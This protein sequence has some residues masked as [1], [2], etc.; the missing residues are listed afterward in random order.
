MDKGFYSVK[1]IV[2]LAI[3]VLLVLLLQLNKVHAQR[4]TSHNDEIM[5]IHGKWA[6][7][8]ASNVGSDPGF[9]SSQYTFSYRRLDSIT[10]MLKFVYPDPRGMEVVYYYNVGNRPLFP[11]A[12][13]A[14]SHN[15]L[16]KEYF[17]VK[18]TG[19]ILLN[20]ETPTW[21]HVYVNYFNWFV[22]YRYGNW[23]IDGKATEVFSLM[24][25]DGTWNGLPLYKKTTQREERAVLISRDGQL[26]YILLTQKQYLLALRSNWENKIRENRKYHEDQEK[27]RREQIEKMK[28]NKTMDPA[29]KE[30]ALANLQKDYDYYIKNQP[31]YISKSDQYFEKKIVLI[32]NYI[33]S[34]S[35]SELQQ[36]VEATVPG[37]FDGSFE[38][39]SKKVVPTQFARINPAYFKKEL[40]RYIPQFI[41][42]YWTWGN[43]TSSLEIKKSLEEKFPVHRLKAL[44]DK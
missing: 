5:S 4:D 23:M 36:A 13:A 24:Q 15:S 19:K 7:E 33:S 12:P 2:L 42:L 28:V 29:I 41:V 11:N 27:N 16:Y 1:D 26:P 40:P 34:H 18:S 32:N 35:E 9:P 44:L 17:Y 43:Y 38:P 20:D 30:K 22:S 14:Y 8:G 6:K 31:T 10:A 39:K 37:D 21:V 25:R 3:L